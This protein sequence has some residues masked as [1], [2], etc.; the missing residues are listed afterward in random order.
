MSQ[1][2][3]LQDLVAALHQESTTGVGAVLSQQQGNPSRLH[4]CAFFSRKLNPAE[5][6]YDI[7]NRELLAVKLAL[8]IGWREPNVRSWYSPTTRTWNTLEPPRGSTLDK[9]IG[10]SSLPDLT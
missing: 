3:P 6:N 2:D 8:G 10:P 5:R 4:P 1:P 7:G 9:L